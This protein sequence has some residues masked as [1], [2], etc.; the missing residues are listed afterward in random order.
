MSKDYFSIA[1]C[2]SLSSVP[3]GAHIH[4][5]GVCGVAMAQ[6]AVALAEQGYVVTGSDKEFYEPMAGLLRDSAVQTYQGFSA[7]RMVTHLGKP[8][9]VVI[10]NSIS[11]GNEEVTAII[12]QALP[13]TIFPK[14]TG[15]FLIGNRHSI[16]ISGTHGK[17]TTTS[18][19][20]H[21]LSEL[22]A[23][24][25]FFVG[26]IIKN[27]P[28]SFVVGSGGI[29]IVEGDEYDSAFF[30]KVPKFDFYKPQTLVITSLE[31]DHADI[32]PDL[33]SIE[34]VFLNLLKSVPP[35]GNIF[36]CIDDHNVKR[37]LPMWRTATRTP[38]ISFGFD[39]E[40]DTRIS[41]P[42]FA[43]GVQS[44]S[45]QI[46]SQAHS[47]SCQLLGSHNARN[48]TAIFLSLQA[49]HFSPIEIIKSI[50]SFTGVRRR[51]D[52]RYQGSDVV[53]IEDFAHHPTAVFET[54]AAIRRGYPGRS[55]KI[56]FEPRSNTSRRKIF[57][58]P[59]QSA[60]KDATAVYLKSVQAR[61]NDDG[62]A[63]MDMNAVVAG[64]KGYGS[65]VSLF[66]TSEALAKQ[67]ITDLKPGD[68]LVVM[69]NG[70]FDGLIDLLTT[71]LADRDRK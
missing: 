42:T 25:S 33:E 15:D 55:L 54:L 56:A 41:E 63:L 61:H 68:V 29:S 11:F 57:E 27:Y 70:S 43:D 35:T 13:Y 24:P 19:G 14:I 37:L 10:G 1:G 30:A 39:S 23:H 65:S 66:D 5:I 9:L 21:A 22:Q 67:M 46:G 3:L 64:I 8:A 36:V 2:S 48:I 20:A 40:S 53:L 62:V 7:Q 6:L 18:L 26:G 31:F 69:S 28:R 4:V 47:L 44:F 17:T 16:V 50:A 49:Q 52:V 12:E 38:I 59:Y 58:V 71:Y 32:Y 45:I 51:Q 60:F 34:A